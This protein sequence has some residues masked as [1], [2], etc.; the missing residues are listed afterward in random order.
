MGWTKQY[1]QD[2]CAIAGSLAVVGDPWTL[3]ILRDA[4]LGVRRFEDFRRGLGMS[5]SVLAG[6]LKKLVRHGVLRVGE[7][8]SP[9][10]RRQYLLTPK[11][12]DLF[13]VMLSLK[14]WGDVHVYGRGA[15]PHAAVHTC[16]CAIDPKFTCAE[17]GEPVEF[18]DLKVDSRAAKTVGEALS[19]RT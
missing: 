15:E 3:L 5:R 6:R 16:G 18:G 9:P 12:R 10:H 13:P 1:E 7:D 17:C 2:T 8:H 11:G 14:A 19:A 4:F